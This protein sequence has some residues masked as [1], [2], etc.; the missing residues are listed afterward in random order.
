MWGDGKSKREILYV[1]DL[2]DAVNFFIN[3]KIKHNLINIGTGM[4]ME[5]QTYAKKIMKILN[6][7]VPIKFDRTRPNGMRRKMLDVSL[8]KKYGWK[9][10][11]SVEDGLKYTYLNFLKR[12][13]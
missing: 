3:K 9:F 4:D 6:Y 8:A 5:I 10:S 1:D 2:A 11:T 12:K 7:K 13:L